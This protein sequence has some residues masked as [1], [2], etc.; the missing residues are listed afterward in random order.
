MK[1]I[2][3]SSDD[4]LSVIRESYHKFNN[5]QFNWVNRNNADSV[6]YLLFKDSKYR[7]GIVVGFREDMS[8]TPFSA[9]F[10]GFSFIKESVKISHIQ[11]ALTL[12]ED[13]CRSNNIKKIRFVLPPLFYHQTFISKEANSL[14]IGGYSIREI[15]LNYHFQTS[16]LDEKYKSNIW[17]SAKKSL[18]RSLENGLLFKPCTSEKERKLSYSVIVK[19]R[20][21]RGFPLRMK[22]SDILKTNN[23]IKKDFFVV[24]LEGVIPVAS[25]IIFY[26]AD[27]I[28]QVVYWG[29]N[30]KYSNLR[31]MN[32]LSYS[33]FKFY[34]D[35]GIRY[36]DVGPST[37]N[38]IPNYGLCEF[39]ESIG[40]QIFPKYTLEKEIG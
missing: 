15:D 20:K 13:F 11:S 4:F 19:N 25:A 27:N 9:P 38:S 22:Y 21:D 14:F 18:N 33:I 16:A 30:T 40:C 32:F 5:A 1:L 24:Y 23:F 2:Q 35:L 34:K 39:K 28:V 3:V 26:V 8:L 29:D 37:E 6:H 12:F 7:L 36:I 17:R 10:G 31:P